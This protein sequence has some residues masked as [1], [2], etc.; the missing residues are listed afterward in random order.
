MTS[1]LA[2]SK[3]RSSRQTDGRFRLTAR[4]SAAILLIILTMTT[5]C[6]G[7]HRECFGQEGRH[8][9]DLAV[10]G[11]DLHVDRPVLH[12][13]VFL[14][15]RANLHHGAEWC[16]DRLLFANALTPG[17]TSAGKSKPVPLAHRTLQTFALHAVRP[18]HTRQRADLP[19]PHLKALRTIV[20]LN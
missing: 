6:A 18:P 11:R 9:V 10:G 17:G 4:A 8:G 3:R 5:A 13:H 19:D 7:L 14:L 15:G 12:S 16:V 2:R 1:L 20:L